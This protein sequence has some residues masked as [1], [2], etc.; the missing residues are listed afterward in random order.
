[1]LNGITSKV[2]FRTN[3]KEAKQI[4]QLA[5]LY[6]WDKHEKFLPDLLEPT[7]LSWSP[8]KFRKNIQNLS[9]LFSARNSL[10]S[11]IIGGRGHFVSKEVVIGFDFFAEQVQK[12]DISRR[13]SAGICGDKQMKEIATTKSY[14]VFW[15]DTIT[16]YL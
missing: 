8:A 6:R 14:S 12:A 9:L 13:H 2:K 15:F 3:V 16:A 4:Y 11:A 10:P 1:M 5:I 7:W